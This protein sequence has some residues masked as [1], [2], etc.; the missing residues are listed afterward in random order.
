MRT[1]TAFTFVFCLLAANVARAQTATDSTATAVDSVVTPTPTPTAAPPPVAAPVVAAPVVAA[2]VA[3]TASSAPKQTLRDRVYY[4]GSVVVSFG[5]V[6]RIGIYPMIAFKFTPKLSLGAEVGYEWLKY[7]DFDQ[8]GNNYGGSLF[9]RYRIVPALYAHA[10]YQMVN[11]EI[12]TSP[13]TSERD[14]V[15]FFLVGGGLSKRIGGNS[16]AYVEVL[17]DLLN[18]DHSPYDDNEPFISAGVGVGF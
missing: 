2:P 1:L 14:W 13:T 12:F 16:W 15:P 8:S 4:G 5:D 10:E 3:T 6:T 7:D 18:D 9:A 17:F 11:Y